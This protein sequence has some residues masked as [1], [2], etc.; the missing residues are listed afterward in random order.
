MRERT[1]D[2]GWLALK[3]KWDR[4]RHQPIAFA[5]AWRKLR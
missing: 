5:F 2:E 1:I 4:L 3:P